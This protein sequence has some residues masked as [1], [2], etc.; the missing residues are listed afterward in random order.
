MSTPN[1]T[2]DPQH[3]I[4]PKAPSAQAPN[5]ALRLPCR[6]TILVAT[7]L[8]GCAFHPQADEKRAAMFESTIAPWVREILRCP[9]CLAS[10]RDELASGDLELVCTGADCGLTYPVTDGIPVLLIDQARARD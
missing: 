2:R 7:I 9:N 5:P 8:G 3:P 6:V 1:H 10:L 4:R